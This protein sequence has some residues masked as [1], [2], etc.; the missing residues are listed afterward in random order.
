MRS[1]VVFASLSIGLLPY[2]FSQS[3][4]CAGIQPQQTIKEIAT[5]YATEDE[6]FMMDLTGEIRAF[7][8]LDIY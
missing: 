8:M 7:Q 5:P 2:V 3:L 1:L 4:V 6:E